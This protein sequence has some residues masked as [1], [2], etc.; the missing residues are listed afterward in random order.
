MGFTG[1]YWSG[2]TTVLCG[3]A[4]GYTIGF[5][6]SNPKMSNS[7]TTTILTTLKMVRTGDK[8]E[9]R[10]TKKAVTIKSTTF[11]APTMHRVS[12]LSEKR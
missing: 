1:W 10:H 4:A 11:L 9:S 2:K 12:W 7:M 6:S 3:S 8:K 5:S